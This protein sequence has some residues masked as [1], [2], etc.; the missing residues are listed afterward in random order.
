MNFNYPAQITQCEDGRHL[1][2]FRDIPHAITD[3][4]TIEEATMEAKG[5]LEEAIASLINDELD[6][7]EPTKP[8]NEELLIRISAQ[9]SAKVAFYIAFK[10][11]GLNKSQLARKLNLN[12]KEVRRMLNAKYQT[13]VSRL[14]EGLA[15]MGYQLSVSLLSAA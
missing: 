15:V 11:S 6:I 14:E 12:E 2:T 3:G 4:A 5:C 9:F 8:V 10:A 7:P 1:V 13:K